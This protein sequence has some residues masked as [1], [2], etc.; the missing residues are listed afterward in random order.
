VLP[1]L[2]SVICFNSEILSIFI[3]K[4]DK[5]GNEVFII[6]GMII[7]FNNVNVTNC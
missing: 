2:S 1:F 6:F 4:Q 3:E 5:N 7:L